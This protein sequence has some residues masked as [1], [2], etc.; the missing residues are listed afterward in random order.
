MKTTKFY[1]MLASGVILS[2]MLLDQAVAQFVYG[3]YAYRPSTAGESLMRGMGDLTRS[4][5][6]RN[7][8]NAEAARTM[9]EVRS[10]EL[11]NRV[12]YTE[13]YWERKRINSENRFYSAEEKAAISQKNLEKQMF[14]RARQSPSKRVG[15]GKVDAVTGAIRWPIELQNPRYD[16]FREDLNEMFEDRADKQ[17]AIG[18]ESYRRITDLT[19][20][21]LRQL[22]KD[23]RNKE[24]GMRQREYLQSKRFIQ[25]LAEEARHTTA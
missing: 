3:G 12:K 18:F 16:Q 6:E 7:M 13:T 4:R 10:N 20:D 5:G 11:D 24:G 2:C 15:G 17:G 22:K 14:Y 21:W 19:D 1:L 25:Q 8:M 9:T 23:L